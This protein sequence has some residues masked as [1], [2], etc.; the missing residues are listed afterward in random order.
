[1]EAVLARLAGRE[2]L[3]PA[4]GSAEIQTWSDQ[5]LLDQAAAI[6]FGHPSTAD[7][8]STYQK[9]LTKLCHPALECSD[10][11]ALIIRTASLA[12]FPSD[13]SLRLFETS[14]ADPPTGKF[15]WAPIS[16]SRSVAWTPLPAE[17]PK[18]KG[19]AWS[20]ILPEARKMTLA[21]NSED[22]W[23]QGSPEE[24]DEEEA[25]VETEAS[26]GDGTMKLHPFLANAIPL[27]G[28]SAEDIREARA[29]LSFIALFLTRATVKSATTM[30][31]YWD[32]KLQGQIESIFGISTEWTL[33]N[34][35]KQFFEV[36]ETKMKKGTG[37][38][39][40]FH[41]VCLAALYHLSM[42]NAG[43]DA[44]SGVALLR[45]S[46]LTHLNGNG[47]TLIG[48]IYDAVRLLH[49]SMNTLLK[50]ALCDQTC[51]SIRRVITFN[52]KVVGIEKPSVLWAWCRYV[53]DS[54]YLTLGVK[55]NLLLSC[56]MAAV[57]EAMIEDQSSIWNMIDLQSAPVGYKEFAKR[58]AA[59]QSS[60]TSAITGTQST[61]MQ[62]VLGEQAV[63]RGEQDPWAHISK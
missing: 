13:L 11:H 31:V 25:S 33:P 1:M 37:L 4:A 12:T 41:K 58:W 59:K 14:L 26:E 3:V 32:S 35:P 47:L 8:T 7:V 5:H 30:K 15:D 53:D 57:R 19:D 29:I 36:L 62:K 54:Q 46:C 45:A 63:Q 21:M 28:A 34:L 16:V 51:E 22:T 60:E 48:M 10:L 40:P 50:E 39:A 38:V 52:E 43:E 49:K 44:K 17:K 9:F 55:H 18:P 61:E 20:D 56:L 27:G 23:E 2:L 24:E 6:K 42:E